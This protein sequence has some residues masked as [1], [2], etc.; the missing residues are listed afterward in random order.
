M[1]DA[2]AVEAPHRRRSIS[3]LATAH[4]PSAAE[5]SLAIASALL[6]ILSF[7]NSELWFLAWLSLVPLLIAVILTRTA[8]RAFVL[9]LVWGTLFFY[10]T[11]WWL[12]Y[13]M[14]RYGHLSPWLAYPL[15]VI[16]V[17]LVAVFPGLACLFLHRMMRSFGPAAIIIA[18]ILW[19]SLELL[20]YAIT[21]LAWNA[22]GYSQAFHPLLIHSARWGGVYAVSFHLLTSNAGLASL[23]MRR[24]R[25]AIVLLAAALAIGLGSWLDQKLNCCNPTGTNPA[26]RLVIVAVQPNVPMDA[27]DEQMPALLDRHLELSR[28]AF[29]EIAGEPNQNLSRLVIWPESPMNFEYA[30]DPHLREVVA[31]F[32]RENRTALLF[33]SLEPAPNGGEHNSAILVNQEGEKTAQ[34]DK[35]RLMPFGEYVPLPRW[36][37]GASSVRGLVGEFTPGGSYTLMP[38]GAFRAGV[39]IC[40]EAAHPAI[41]RNFTNEGADVLVNISN[42]GYLG[43]TAVMR[44]HLSNAVMRAAENGRPLIRVTNTGITANVAADGAV[45]E[46]TPGY[47]T[48]VR[49]WTIVRNQAEPSFYARRGDLFAYACGLLSLGFVTATFV[50]FRRPS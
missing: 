16:P 44:Q 15:L 26:D 19:V 11:C 7:P 5:V 2:V 24:W 41:A 40:I 20:R 6:T 33:N 43:P 49:T 30:R 10:V 13:S 35:I 50:N 28:M 36:L 22:L 48:T 17:V 25:P 14:I 46:I 27:S 34:Y 4:T 1:H 8:G 21:G 47:Q 37:P 45:D 12:T 9:G 42:D 39:F 38:L 3:I 32:A 31:N 29:A 18:P 23:L